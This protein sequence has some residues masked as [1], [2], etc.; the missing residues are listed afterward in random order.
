MSR[1]FLARVGADGRGLDH[2]AEAADLNYGARRAR[3]RNQ[4][5]NADSWAG[6]YLGGNL[7]YAWGSVDNNLTKPSGFAGGVQAGY[8]WQQGP[9]VFG[10][11]GD[12]QATGADDTFAPW[13]FSNPCSARC[14]AGSAM[15]SATSSLRHR[16]PRLR[17]TP[18]HHLRH[19]GIPHQCRLDRRRRRRDGLCAELERQDRT[20]TSI[21]PTAISSISRRVKWLPVRVSASRRELPLLRTRKSGFELPAASSRRDFFVAWTAGCRAPKIS[22]DMQPG[23][24][25]RTALGAARLRAAHQVLDGASILADPL[26][27][28]ILG[29]RSRSRSIMPKLTRWG[30]DAPVHCRALAHCRRCPHRCGQ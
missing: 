14:A 21:W 7:G 16:R 13:K 1:F 17:R 6:P 23:Q 9:W 20:P 2:S 30:P 10:V 4:P 24:P 27:V 19:V 29:R 25:S 26:A 5:L 8:N 11:E 22:G 28:R 12:I 18:R 15:R 3:Y